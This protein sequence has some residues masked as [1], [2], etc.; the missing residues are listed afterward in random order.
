LWIV[1]AVSIF[2]PQVTQFLFLLNKNLG[3]ERIRDIIQRFSL[4]FVCVLPLLIG[5]ASLFV[6]N[7]PPETLGGKASQVMKGF[8]HCAGLRRWHCVDDVYLGHRDR[9]HL[10]QA[11][12][13]RTR[14]DSA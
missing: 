13:H 6:D 7:K 14:A 2:A 10:H 1:F 9:Y 12:A 11:P 4:V 8:S 3:T 5:F